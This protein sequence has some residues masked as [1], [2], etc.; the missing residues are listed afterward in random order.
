MG[1]VRRVANRM[2]VVRVNVRSKASDGLDG[3][4]P[5]EHH[6]GRKGEGKGEEQQSLN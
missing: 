4:N 3:G 5:T 1:G 2:T 6:I